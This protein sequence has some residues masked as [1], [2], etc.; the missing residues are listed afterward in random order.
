V[1]QPSHPG[2]FPTT[3]WS[4]VAHAA[5]PGDPGAREALETLCRDYWYPLYAFARRSGLGPDDAADIVQ[6]TFAALLGRSGL[7]AADPTRGRF[8]TYLL[9]ACR[10]HLADE[11]FRAAARKRGGDRAL[12]PIDAAGAEGHYAAERAERLTPERLYERAWATSLLERALGRLRGEYEGSGKG[13]LFAHLEPTLAGGPGAEPHAVT[14]E[15]LGMT[16]GAVQVAAHR[17]RRRFR[18]LVREEIA[19][20]VDDAAG[21]EDEVRMLFAALAP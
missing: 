10:H 21:V 5:D 20:T 12:V 14:A 6:G 17:L 3:C 16:E 18:A 13:A 1:A 15:A 4:R 2:R 19:A 9:A 7:A 8:R 11:R